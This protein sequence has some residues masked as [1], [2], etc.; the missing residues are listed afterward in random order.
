[1]F[2]TIIARCLSPGNN[3]SEGGSERL[4]VIITMQIDGCTAES[5]WETIP[6]RWLSEEVLWNGIVAYYLLSNYKNQ[7]GR[8]KTFLVSN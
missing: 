2:T 1:M 8:L 6:G 7:S 5:S 4:Q 3:P